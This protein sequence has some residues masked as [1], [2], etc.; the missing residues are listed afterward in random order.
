MYSEFQNSQIND[1]LS[2]L[3]SQHLN[4][5]IWDIFGGN[6]GVEMS[7]PFRIFG[8]PT[9]NQTNVSPYKINYYDERKVRM[10][11]IQMLVVL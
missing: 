11:S 5:Q 7:D 8:T 3:Q 9:I 2:H 10:I 4:V 1:K 6:S